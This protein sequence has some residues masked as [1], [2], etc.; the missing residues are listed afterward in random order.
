MTKRGTCLLAGLALAVAAAVPATGATVPKKHSLSG[1]AQVVTI[2]SQ[3]TPPNTTSTGAGI[4]KGSIGSGAIVGTTTFSGTNFTNKFRV[5]LLHG[6][7]KGTLS[8]TF[9]VNPDGSVSSTGTAKITGGTGVYKGATGKLTF[10]GTTPAN[11]NVSTFQVKG[12]ATY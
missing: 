1:T 6:T 3:G 2:S 7:F 9:T 11:S 4:V 5:F 10:T 8:G 12:S